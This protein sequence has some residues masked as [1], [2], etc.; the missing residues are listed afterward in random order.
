M[1]CIQLTE[2]NLC[3]LFASRERPMVCGSFKADADTCGAS[4]E[5]ALERLARLE[6]E[7]SSAQYLESE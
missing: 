1:R 4:R 6:A 5:D 7:T 2:D 3:R